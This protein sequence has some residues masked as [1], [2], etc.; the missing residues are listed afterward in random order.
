M[1]CIENAGQNSGKEF[2]RGK[3]NVFWKRRNKTK[4]IRDENKSSLGKR[5]AS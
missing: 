4:H 2:T 3:F 1:T 5:N